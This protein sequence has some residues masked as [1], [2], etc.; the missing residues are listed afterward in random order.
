MKILLLILAFIVCTPVWAEQVTILRVIDGD[1]VVT[2]KQEHIRLA[3]IDA[4]EHDQVFGPEATF[5]LKDLLS[6][7]QNI[8]EL[9]RV[10]TD[11]YHR[12]VG[13]LIKQ[14]GDVINF[15]MI[16]DGYAWSYNRYSHNPA[17]G[18]AYQNFAE[19]HELGLWAEPNPTPPWVWRKQ[20]KRLH[21]T[22]MIRRTWTKLCPTY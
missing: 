11:K 14:D 15:I 16:A 8:V 2:T 21:G 9:D 10:S 4:P 18:M 19:A 3:D 20:H 12:T 7:E 6:A 13:Y 22:W 5:H 1:T 17:L